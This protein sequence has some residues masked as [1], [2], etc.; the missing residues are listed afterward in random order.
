MNTALYL[1]KCQSA[2]WHSAKCRGAILGAVHFFHK[3]EIYLSNK[4]VFILFLGK[5]TPLT[6]KVTVFNLFL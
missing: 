4:N 1:S 6:T 3:F 2:E 5:L